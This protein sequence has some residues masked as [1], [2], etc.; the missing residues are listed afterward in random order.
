MATS[1][2][3]FR[4]SSFQEGPASTPSHRSQDDASA[5]DLVNSVLSAALPMVKV[6]C[7]RLITKFNELG[8]LPL[9][10][11]LSSYTLRVRDNYDRSAG[12]QKVDAAVDPDKL[13]T[14]LALQLLHVGHANE[15]WK[16]TAGGGV[17]G[18]VGSVVGGV[19]GGVGSV[20]GGV[21]GGVSNVV[22]GVV[23]GPKR[24]SKPLV[25]GGAGAAGA[26]VGRGGGDE[27]AA[28]A[29]AAAT[30]MV[31][32]DCSVKM[33]L[34]FSSEV[35]FE[36]QGQRWYTPDIGNIGVK[37]LHVRCD[38]RLWLDMAGG[39][40]RFA[41]V[42]EPEIVWDL[43]VKILGLDLPDAIED[44]LV[45]FC[46]KKVLGRFSPENPILV[47]FNISNA[48]SGAHITD[49]LANAVH[50]AISEDPELGG[51]SMARNSSDGAGGA[52]GGGGAARGGGAELRLLRIGVSVLGVA[53]FLSCFAMAAMLGWA[54]SQL[55]TLQD[56]V[57]E[58]GE[59]LGQCFEAVL[60]GVA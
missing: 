51:G 37:D 21:V 38:L 3:V 59:R 27:L 6:G 50:K 25:G 60:P 46:L 12:K 30:S 48:I 5:V 28:M 13:I 26:N 56:S 39:E 31:K 41:F 52:A 49:S 16:A 8:G 11:P 17:V 57:E 4:A 43:E 9:A 2:P 29:A 10:A 33:D 23:G 42:H 15:A 40:V 54:L 47:P 1:P 24:S 45:P 53:L 14:Q 34:V 22:G 58:Q 35:C 18:S 20:V 19:V 36:L 7:G 55:A 44:G 32:V